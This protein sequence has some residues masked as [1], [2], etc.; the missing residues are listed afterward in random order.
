MLNYED[1][2]KSLYNV[3]IKHADDKA[4]FKYYAKV[5]IN[6]KKNRYFYSKDEYLAYM[7]NKSVAADTAVDKAKEKLDTESKKKDASDAIDKAV[8]V[9]SF[10]LGG[11]L[12][13]TL[14][15][16]IREKID[17]N[18]QFEKQMADLKE[19]NPLPSLKLKTES[20]TKDQDQGAIN[21]MYDGITY[22]YSNNCSYCTMAYDLRQRGYDVEANP[23]DPNAPVL[24]EDI[25]D[26]YDGAEVRDPMTLAE[27]NGVS[28]ET[29][30]LEQA[31]ELMEQDLLEEGE[32]ARGHFILYW[33]NGGGHD[34]IWEVE[35]G[36]L[37]LRDCQNNTKLKPINYIQY[38]CYFSYFRSDNIQPN[39]KC[40]KTVSNKK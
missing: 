22:E 8:D 32:G 16:N 5:P 18:D 30:T 10:L 17:A 7:K 26:W 24:L 4:N 28:F 14:V 23:A 3:A 6:S 31:A 9:V 36:E 39:A 37:W 2:N 33:A 11:K 1:I 34:V 12:G 15:R 13:Q 21:P 29:M 19:N 38:S 35:N 40:L 20:T 27:E 25:A